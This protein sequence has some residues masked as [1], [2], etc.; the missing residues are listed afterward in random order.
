MSGVPWSAQLR[1]L[2]PYFHHVSGD[3]RSV[4][5]LCTLWGGCV[6]CKVEAT[7]GAM[8]YSVLEQR[9]CADGMVA[10]LKLF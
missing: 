1:C 6:L 5:C 10:V 8:Q 7:H 3:V 2:V 9:T 4:A